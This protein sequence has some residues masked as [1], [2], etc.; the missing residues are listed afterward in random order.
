[1]PDRNGRLLGIGALSGVV[2]GLLGGGNGVLTVPALAHYTRLSRPAVH[3]TST[4]AAASVC[5]V[6]ALVYWLVGG[7]IDLRAGAGMLVGG[8]IGGFYG[9]KLVARASETLLR[10]LLIAILVLTATKLYLDAAGLDPVSD[11]AVVPADLLA[12]WWFVVPLSVVVGVLVGAWAGAMG[13]G[14]G[15]LA[16]PALVL[17]FGV[18]L[19]TAAGTSLLVFLP[20]CL[21]GGL[22][23]WR[24]GTADLRIA[25]LV[26]LA[27]APGAA[28][29][30]LLAL[31]LGNVVLGVVFG[32]FAAVM[33]L[34]EIVQLV[35][36][37]RRRPG[38]D[39]G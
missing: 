18:D 24:Q 5:A 16:V 29:G 37:Q 4:L 6:G 2:G 12:T 35:R 26:G 31:A 17:L 32:T 36:R 21:V 13:L 30:A 38:P 25:N 3:G 19:H 7:T 9:A 39:A 1:M 23:H 27:A 34:R 22:S 10:V 28:A 11:G 8:M 15:L 14:G 33:A 20:N